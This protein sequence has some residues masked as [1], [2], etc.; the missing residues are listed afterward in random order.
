MICNFLFN[1]IINREIGNRWALEE[2][3]RNLDKHYLLVGVTEELADFVKILEAT[4]PRF[5][6]GAYDHF[7]HSNDN[8]SYLI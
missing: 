4:L 1:S 7:M 3:K 5:F 6:K 8:Y 2:A